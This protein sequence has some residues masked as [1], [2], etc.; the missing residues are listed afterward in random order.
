MASAFSSSPNGRGVSMKRLCSFA[1]TE[2]PKAFGVVCSKTAVNFLSDLSFI[3]F[4]DEKFWRIHQPL[5]FTSR[6]DL[7]RP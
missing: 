7:K 4:R 5:H 2:H 6:K 3:R 1:R